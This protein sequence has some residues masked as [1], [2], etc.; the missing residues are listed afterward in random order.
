[1]N[2]W[3]TS[4]R[5][6]A[7]YGWDIENESLSFHIQNNKIKST[8]ID[9][10]EIPVM[11]LVAVGSLD[12]TITIWDLFKRNLIFTIDL[13]QGGIHSLIY[14]YTYQVLV[15]AGYENCISIY[16]I[17][18]IYLDHDLIGKLIGHNSMV[19]AIQCIEKTP[20][21]ISA[22]DNGIIK[23]W[24][25]R[26]FKCIQ[27]VDVGSKTVITKLLDIHDMGKI[28]FIGSRVNFLDFDEPFDNGEKKINNKK[29]FIL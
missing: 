9:L 13:S 12:R 4:D 25:I 29:N 22:D 28:C 26:S 2:L 3:L 21:L 8:I 23:V 7:I 11:K 18:P 6:N 1:M 20:L 16:E 17:N 14:F 19:T 27:T 10:K 24:D 15:T 5:S